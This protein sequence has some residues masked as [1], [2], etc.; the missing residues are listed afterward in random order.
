MRWIAPSPAQEG[1]EA[2]LAQTKTESGGHPNKV[3]VRGK[4]NEAVPLTS[5]LTPSLPP[6]PPLVYPLL[7]RVLTIPGPNRAIP[8]W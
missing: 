1:V 5:N 4:A 6:P 2:V 3:V 7:F 8:A